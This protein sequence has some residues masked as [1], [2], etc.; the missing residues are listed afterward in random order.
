MNDLDRAALILAGLTAAFLFLLFAAWRARRPRPEPAAP[1][2]PK[3]AR[4]P[5]ESRFSGFA[6]NKEPAVEPIEMAPSRLARISRAA[7]DRPIES[8][9]ADD[10][11]P[12]AESI[13]EPQPEPAAV[14][15]LAEESPTESPPP[16]P[17]LD[18]TALDALATEVERQAHFADPAPAGG[19]IR[20][21]PRI[22]PR[23]AI[24]RKSWMG[25]R[26]NLPAAAPWPTIDGREGDFIAQIACADLPPMLWDGLGP[27]TGWLAFFTHP[28]NGAATALHMAEDGAPRDPPRAVGAAC[29]RPHGIDDAELAALSIRALPEWPVDMVPEAGG[30]RDDDAAGALLAA[31]Y[32]IADP[33]FHPFDWPSMLAMAR[34]LESRILALPT[35]GVPPADASDEL[36]QAIAD[37]AEANRGAAE[38]TAEIV[39]IIRE[40]AAADTGFLPSDATAVMAAL[41]AI[42]WT[43][44]TARPDPEYGADEVETLALPLTRR[45]PDGDLW[46]DAYRALLFDHARHA[47]CANP[48]RLSAPARGFFEPLW[49]AM[50]AD[51]VAR[52]GDFPARRASGFDAERDVVMLE[53]PPGALLGLAHPDGG[54]LIFAIRKADLAAGDFSRVRA[55]AGD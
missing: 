45:R 18:E 11:A 8:V 40:S 16:A 54:S 6:R 9:W 29:F 3:I 32:D 28:D 47:Y 24:L 34:I 22:P 17:A 4:E 10:P 19:G 53:L 36:A 12:V 52:M 55:L 50:A 26:P 43:R 44:V 20:L 14:M 23:D 31:D 33:A 2:M 37:A 46:I 39:A 7:I 38:R 1:N 51:G 35:D 48:D 21:M 13:A 27:R 49:T 41:H 25:G 15:P 5:R 42:R 30:P